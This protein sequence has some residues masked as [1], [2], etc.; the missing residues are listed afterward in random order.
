MRSFRDGLSNSNQFGDLRRGFDKLINSGF[1][2][3]N[4]M[5][6]FW[7]ERPPDV[8]VCCAGNAA[9]GLFLEQDVATFRSSMELIYMG[10]VQTIKAV[11]KPMVARRDGQIIIVGSAMSVVGFMGYSTYAPAKHALRGLADTLRNELVGFNVAVQIAYP[12]DTDT[13]GFEH[14][15]RTKPIETMKMVPLDV[16][17]SSPFLSPP[18]PSPPLTPLCACRCQWTSTLPRRSLRACC[19]APRRASTTCPRLIRSSTS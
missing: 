14:E 5:E 13:P 11:I 8:V 4:G 16:Y 7:Q 2:L 9:P 6:S 15:N 17:S 18:L 10:T 3:N 19:A 1:L 12:P